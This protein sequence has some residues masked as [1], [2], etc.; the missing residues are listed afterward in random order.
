[1]T[2]ARVSYFWIISE[3]KLKLIAMSQC[4][5]HH[6]L[7]IE[8]YVWEAVVRGLQGP[9]VCVFSLALAQTGSGQTDCE[10]EFPEKKRDKTNK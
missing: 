4:H 5:R 7:A 8:K 2:L 3:H 10:G 1:M 6:R 9:D